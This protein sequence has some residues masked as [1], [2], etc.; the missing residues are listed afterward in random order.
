MDVGRHKVIGAGRERRLGKEWPLAFHRRMQHIVTATG[1]DSLF[2]KRFDPDGQYVSS[3]GFPIPTSL[4]SAVR[5][6]KS[7]EPDASGLRWIWGEHLIWQRATV[8]EQT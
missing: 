6:F 2:S 3:A 1:V 5:V 7:F 4:A 8:S